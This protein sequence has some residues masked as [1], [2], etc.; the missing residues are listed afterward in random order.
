MPIPFMHFVC[1]SVLEMFFYNLLISEGIIKRPFGFSGS[2]CTYCCI[3]SFIAIDCLSLL[4]HYKTKKQMNSVTQCIANNLMGFFTLTI[5]C[6]HFK[7]MSLGGERG[8]FPWCATG[9]ANLEIHYM[10]QF[11]GALQ[12]NHRP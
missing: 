6:F 12:I 10:I 1:F 9:H 11:V 4:C 3:F 2:R 7:T 5:L 8:H